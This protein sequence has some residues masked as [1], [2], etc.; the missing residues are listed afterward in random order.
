MASTH[1]QRNQTERCNFARLN[2]AFCAQLAAAHRAQRQSAYYHGTKIGAHLADLSIVSFKLDDPCSIEKCSAV[3]IP[4]RVYRYEARD[5][6]EFNSLHNT[7]PGMF[8]S[9]QATPYAVRVG[10][11]AGS[12]EENKRVLLHV[13]ADFCPGFGASTVDPMHADELRSPVLKAS[14]SFCSYHKRFHICDELCVFQVLTSNATTVCALS[15][16]VGA[17]DSVSFSFGDGTGTKERSEQSADANNND[18]GAGEERKR[19][20]S[21]ATRI[22]V[23]QNGRSTKPA[24]TFEELAVKR[25][26]QRID[27]AAKRKK[28]SKMRGPSKVSNRSLEPVVVRLDPSETPEHPPELKSDN[29]VIEET[30]VTITPSPPNDFRNRGMHDIQY[31]RD[32]LRKIYARARLVREFSLGRHIE[33]NTFFT[34]NDL[35]CRHLVLATEIIDLMV[36]SEQVA[37]V[38]REAFDRSHEIARKA[39]QQYIT[40]SNKANAVVTF[41]LLDQIYVE[42]LTGRRNYI[43]I[44]IDESLRR[45]ILTKTALSVVEFYFNLRALDLGSVDNDVREDYKFEYFV[46]AIVDMMHSNGYVKEQVC[47]L[48]QDTFVIGEFCADQGVLRQTGVPEHLINTLKTGIKEIIERACSLVPMRLL[49]ATMIPYIDMFEVA[50][51]STPDEVGPR[52]VKMF[53]DAR[54]RRLANLS[55][56]VSPVDNPHPLVIDLTAH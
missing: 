31:A 1:R 53:L 24:K 48:E 35:L 22:T 26:Q 51:R 50:R 3:Q 56:V 18:A 34:D 8:V 9:A 5:D 11:L 16:T 47:I 25:R 45:A 29:V 39:V 44:V 42:A 38:Q 6:A 54:R 10:L 55:T 17:V 41:D 23:K 49:E 32:E 12:E 30:R 27:S 52:V 19:K 20:R 14:V 21:A 33:E 43:S 40:T 46:V 13:C 36:F 4:L 7:M 2:D 37:I 15:R 28:A